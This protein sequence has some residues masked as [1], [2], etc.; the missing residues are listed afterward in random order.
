MNKIEYLRYR[1]LKNNHRKYHKYCNLWVSNVTK[2]QCN[3][4]N[5]EMHRLG[6]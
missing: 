1:F 2:E 3:Y 6:L 5:T 4:F